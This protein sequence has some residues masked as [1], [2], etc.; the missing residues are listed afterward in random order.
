MKAVA[1]LQIS[2]G[3]VAGAETAANDVETYFL[4]LIRMQF[5]WVILRIHS[6]PKSQANVT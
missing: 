3:Q 2:A 4:M 1:S 6:T 5:S